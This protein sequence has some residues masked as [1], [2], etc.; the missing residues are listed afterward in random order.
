[1]QI[2]IVPH[3][4]PLNH[5]LWKL[6]YLLAILLPL[7]FAPTSKSNDTTKVK[8]REVVE[9]HDRLL[10]EFIRTYQLWRR[11]YGETQRQTEEKAKHRIVEIPEPQPSPY[12]AAH[13]PGRKRARK[14]PAAQNKAP[15]G[16]AFSLWRKDARRSYLTALA[17][18]SGKRTLHRLAGPLYFGGAA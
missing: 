6:I 2:R 8:Q 18:A 10:E 11:L 5:R 4:K 1:M 13:S 17:S 7:M 14:Y 9:Y 12:P 16:V 3:T 15:S